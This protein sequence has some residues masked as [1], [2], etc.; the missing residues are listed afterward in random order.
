MLL[1][2][3]KLFYPCCFEDHFS[4]RT[5]LVFSLDSLG[6]GAESTLLLFWCYS[7]AVATSNANCINW[8]F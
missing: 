2:K 3:P 6:G 8:L 5:L 4:C 7:L 1:T